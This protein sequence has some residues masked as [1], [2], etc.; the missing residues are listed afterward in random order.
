M[1]QRKTDG[2]TV[3]LSGT[4]MSAEALRQERPQQPLPTLT[5]LY[6]P[7]LRRI[8]DL[9]PLAELSFGREALISRYQPELKAPGRLVGEPLADPYISRRPLRLRATADGGVE[10]LLGE[11]R[12]GVVAQG[13]S[14][15][16]ASTFSRQEVDRGVTL[17]LA[18][19]VVLL[20]HR[21]V[22]VPVRLPQ[23]FGLIGDSAGLVRVR[24]DVQ[25]VAD[26]EVPV[27]LRGETGTGKELVARAIHGA[28]S[29]S[30]ATFLAVNL[31]A[32]PPA[33][34]ASELFG[35]LK[36]SFTGSVAHQEGYFRRA[37]G[38]TLFLDEIG[39]APPEVQVMLLRALETGEI[40]PVGSQTPQHVDVRVIAATDAD[41]EDRVR[42]GSFRGPLLHRLS[43]YEIWLPP[44]RE[45]RDDVGRLLLHFLREELA[46]IDEPWRLNP[47][48][49]DC[50]PLWLRPHLVARLARYD[51][52]G[53]VRQLR[54]VA[55]QLVIGSRGLPVLETG[56]QVERL[57]REHAGATSESRLSV[58][59]PASGVAKGTREWR[60]PSEIGEDE[61][62]SALRLNRWDLKAT[63][64]YLHVSRTSLYALVESCPKVR[65][66]TE[67]STGEITRCH[68]ECGGDLDAMAERL[69][70]SKRGL[71][72][73]LREL[74]LA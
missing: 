73:R 7:D 46:R 48:D 50:N 2:S 47:D 18:A 4:D 8:G 43:G 74:G 56:P 14:I 31:G 45:R 42:S 72:R 44:L 24:A 64:A 25:R 61:L 62:L 38:G 70:V 39:E 13:T 23:P 16:Q 22:G 40:F 15:L 60:K 27:L 58:D 32:I 68:T 20:L 57:L 67:L 10:I 36:G 65:T 21:A 35:S 6:H 54:N 17:E 9:V 12:T 51:W 52:P 53:N 63:S 26:L 1:M 3:G 11:S 69:E 71:A 37:H 55:R 29:R 49:P 34:S 5:V 33:L 66:V 28:S 41:L 19:R 59:T 30:R